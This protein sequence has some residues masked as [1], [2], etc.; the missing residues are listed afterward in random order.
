MSARILV[1]D[2]SRIVHQT[3]RLSLSDLA[4]I[5][6]VTDATKAAEVEGPWDL[7]LV[8]GDYEAQLPG[9]VGALRVSSPQL[10]LILAVGVMK[11]LAPEILSRLGPCEVVRKPWV[12]REFRTLVE[13]MLAEEPPVVESPSPDLPD[14]VPAE[15]SSLPPPLNE[16]ALEVITS[17]PEAVEDQDSPF[18]GLVTES[19]FGDAPSTQEFADLVSAVPEA[20]SGDLPPIDDDLPPVEGDEP[21]IGALEAEADSIATDLDAGLSALEAS[22]GDLPPL[23]HATEPATLPPEVARQGPDLSSQV[24]EMT[25]PPSG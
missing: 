18:A 16:A 19:E 21:P 25:T 2:Q 9:L 11:E 23:E 1:I 10:R 8:S 22:L 20:V 7:A 3:V 15:E 4:E 14:L 6:A 12:S 17:P 5:T 24:L 13:R